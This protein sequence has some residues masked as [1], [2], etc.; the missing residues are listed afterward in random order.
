MHLF[1]WDKFLRLG[2]NSTNF[3][4]SSMKRPKMQSAI[5]YVQSSE[6]QTMPKNLPFPQCRELLQHPLS[7]LL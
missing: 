5:K 6:T 4:N 3:V 1:L 2:N 7:V